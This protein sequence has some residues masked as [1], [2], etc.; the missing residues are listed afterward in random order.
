MEP[1]EPGMENGDT[2]PGPQLESL[3]AHT[4]EMVRI[5]RKTR[6]QVR[7]SRSSSLVA[8]R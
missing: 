3:L 5:F 4:H 8:Y 1:G 7:K 2:V 6:A